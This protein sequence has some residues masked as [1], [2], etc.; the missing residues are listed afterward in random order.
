MDRMMKYEDLWAECWECG[1]PLYLTADQIRS[2]IIEMGIR[3]EDMN[4]SYVLCSSNCPKCRKPGTPGH[5][6]F[7]LAKV[8]ASK[9]EAKMIKVH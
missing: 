1:Q 3:I 8:K 5:V 7:R 6:Y 9:P 2:I 4:S